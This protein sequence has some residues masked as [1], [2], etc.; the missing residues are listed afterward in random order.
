MPSYISGVECTDLVK[1][2]HL[3]G[4]AGEKLIESTRCLLDYGFAELLED[5]REDISLAPDVRTEAASAFL[6]C[7]EIRNLASIAPRG[8]YY[9]KPYHL[10]VEPEFTHEITLRAAPGRITLWKVSSLQA[11]EWF[12]IFRLGFFSSKPHF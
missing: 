1:N 4:A 7:E 10:S 8:R 9:I 11:A 5:I 12:V 2:P 6:R 3:H